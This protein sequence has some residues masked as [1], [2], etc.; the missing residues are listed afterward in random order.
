MNGQLVDEGILKMAEAMAQEN[1]N[2]LQK[3]M[4]A[5]ETCGNMSERVF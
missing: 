3:N 1:T 5:V 2:E 4:G